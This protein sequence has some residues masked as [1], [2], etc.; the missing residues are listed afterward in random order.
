MPSLMTQNNLGWLDYGLQM[1]RDQTS[2][3][4]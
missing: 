3:F 2:L 4:C 1:H